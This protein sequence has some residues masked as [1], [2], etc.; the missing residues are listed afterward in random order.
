[1]KKIQ[2]IIGSTREGRSGD[3]VAKW[4]F[5]LAEKRKD[6]KAE[7]IDLKEWN[8]PF[9]N[10]PNSPAS[11]N[12]SYD[13]TKKWSKKISEGDAYILVT[14]EY[15]HGYPASLKN[16]LDHLSREWNGKPVG[17]VSYGGISAGTRAVQ[18]LKQVALELR[19]IPSHDEVNI[20][21]IWQA[22]DA[23]GNL[24]DAAA[25]EPRAKML[26]DG[27]VALLK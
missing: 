20:P 19:M 22:F 27:V 12:Y 24:K 15:N 8:L 9:F 16:A 4:I 13:Y 25:L 6:F 26:F 14:P 5:G 23:D 3:K 17:F 1:M 11:G 7:L 2:I 21:F 18:Q 10:D